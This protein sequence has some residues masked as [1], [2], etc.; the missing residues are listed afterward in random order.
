MASGMAVAR[1]GHTKRHRSHLEQ[2]DP[3]LKAAIVSL[4]LSPRELRDDPF[5]SLARSITGQQLSVQA[6]ATIFSR[7]QKL[8]RTS[9]FP[10]PKRFLAMKTGPLRKAGLSES[11]VGYMRNL[12][13]FVISHK[14]EF[15]RLAKL[16]DDEVIALLT[17]IKGIGVWTAEMF[18]MFSLGRDDVFSYGDLGLRNAMQKVYKLRKPPSKR[19]AERISA[20][21]KPY[22]THASLYLWQTLKNQP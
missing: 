3:I 22:R 21:W 1:F 11:K 15:S 9:T 14:K 10:T 16:S 6:A 17:Q 7:L 4:K 18:L 8:F 12:A 19:T 13:Q 2:S 20:K 5:Y